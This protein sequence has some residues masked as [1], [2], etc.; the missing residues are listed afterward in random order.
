MFELNLP[1]DIVS[2][3]IGVRRRVEVFQHDCIVG[4]RIPS[5]EQEYEFPGWPIYSR[6]GY[7]AKFVPVGK[8]NEVH[9]FTT[10]KSSVIKGQLI[11]LTILPKAESQ[12]PISEI[13]ILGRTDGVHRYIW[14]FEVTND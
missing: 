3:E 6:L 7:P 13:A 5:I 2:L 14:N 4:L 12:V 10:I 8:E 1:R 9:K 11:Q